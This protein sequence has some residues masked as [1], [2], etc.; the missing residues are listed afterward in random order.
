MHHHHHRHTS[1]MVLGHLL[2]HSSLTYPEVSSKVFHDS[3]YQLV[4]SI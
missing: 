4:S 1:F 3:Y 2:T